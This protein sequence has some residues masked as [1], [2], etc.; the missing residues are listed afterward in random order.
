MR[1]R[2]TGIISI[3]Y[4]RN[5]VLLAVFSFSRCTFSPAGHF[6]CLRLVNFHAKEN[7]FYFPAVI[8]DEGDLIVRKCLLMRHLPCK[9]IVKDDLELPLHYRGMTAGSAIHVL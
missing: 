3:L 7:S 1:L 4:C 2:N 5:E 6:S 8:L 9:V